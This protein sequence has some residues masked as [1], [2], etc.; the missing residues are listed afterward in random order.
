MSS[1]SKVLIIEDEED[2]ASFIQME[3]DCEG[4]ETEVA[5]D[6]TKGLMALR[7]FE[8][9]LV[10]LDRMLPQMNGI[11]VCKRIKQTTDIPVLMLT[12]LGDIDD[13]V[14][15]LD[16][17]ANDY[18]VKPFALNELLARIRVQIRQRKPKSKT[19]MEFEDLSIDTLTREVKRNGRLINLSPKEFDL[20]SILLGNPKHVITKERIIETVWGWDFDGDDNVLEVCMH[21]LREKIESKDLPKII[22]TVRGIGYVIKSPV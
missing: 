15:G 8:P 18:L 11:E 22:H 1:K 19:K 14:E 5:S 17:G 3:L 20:L 4:Y 7:K 6:G 2:I 9:D 12:A 16:A 10:I 13:R 21:G